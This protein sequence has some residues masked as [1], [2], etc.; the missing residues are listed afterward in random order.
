MR[1][2]PLYRPLRV[3]SHDALWH[4]VW[5]RV[6]LYASWQHFVRRESIQ[7]ADLDELEAVAR[8]EYDK[9]VASY[10]RREGSSC[11]RVM[12]LPA[13]LDPALL[14][15]LGT[16]WSLSRA[17]ADA[18]LGG[19]EAVL[20]RYEARI[21]LDVIDWAGTLSARFHPAHGQIEEEITFLP[22]SALFVYRVETF[23]PRI[24]D[25]PDWYR[26]DLRERLR[27]AVVEIHEERM[28]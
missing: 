18:Y 15:P 19:D 16:D 22:G 28:V 6:Q 11:W 1:R 27:G 21:D 5:D 26:R 25:D 2:P 13:H 20:A 10:R 7:G 17:G 8:H 12:S 4:I 3:G 24:V 14:E 9:L 23:D